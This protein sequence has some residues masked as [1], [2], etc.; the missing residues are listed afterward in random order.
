MCCSIAIP[1]GVSRV[2]AVM[3]VVSLSNWRQNRLLPQALQKPRSAV[4]EDRYQV[5]VCD[6]FSSRCSEGALVMAA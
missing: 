1:V 5:R 3:L 4:A 6:D 2:P